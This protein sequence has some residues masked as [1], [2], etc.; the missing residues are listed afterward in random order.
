L[1]GFLGAGLSR[2]WLEA[3][4]RNDSAVRLYQR[5][6]FRRR[7]TLYKAVE[8]VAQPHVAYSLSNVQYPL[9]NV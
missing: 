4:A 6:G 1:D 2:G 8:I 7:K 5:L 3:T 9:S